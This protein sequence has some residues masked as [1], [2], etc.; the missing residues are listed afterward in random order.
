MSIGSRR[1]AVV[2]AAALVAT[3]AL[4]AA[5]PSV[6]TGSMWVNGTGYGSV[7]VRGDVVVLGATNGPGHIQVRTGASGASIGLNAR[8]RRI[9]PHRVVTV[10]VRAGAQFGVTSNWAPFMVIVRGRGISATIFGSGIITFMGR[11]TYQG[12]GTSWSRRWT[13]ASVQLR[14][15]SAAGRGRARA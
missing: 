1:T 13:R 3:A 7:T 12:Y 4:A 15:P 11:G 10:A 2:A 9:A 5:V 6:N 14:Q 8:R